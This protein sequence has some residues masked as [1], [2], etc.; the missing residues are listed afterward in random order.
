MK[1]K[2][3]QI[4]LVRCLRGTPPAGLFTKEAVP[5]ASVRVLAAKMAVGI[6]KKLVIQYSRA[7]ALPTTILARESAHFA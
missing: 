3:C 5:I 7:F 6:V 2:I 4:L 1:Q